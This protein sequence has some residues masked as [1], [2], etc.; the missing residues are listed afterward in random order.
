M[1][2]ITSVD[3]ILDFAIER[4]EESHRFYTNLAHII[5]K[6]EMRKIFEQFAKE[7]LGHKEKLLGIK[8]GKLM[9][10]AAKKVTDLKIADYVVDVAVGSDMSYQEALIVAMKKEKAAFRL[11]TNLANIVDDH[12]LSS[13][14]QALAQEEAKHKLRFEI[15]YD[16]NILTDN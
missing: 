3:A 11:Y 9:L 8:R 1:E 13:V 10:P 16:E 7:E 2:K 15:E 12:N 5:E 14:F 4:E 6:P